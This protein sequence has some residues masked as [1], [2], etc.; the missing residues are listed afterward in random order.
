M[1][2]WDLADWRT[3]Y[4][5]TGSL[6]E[7]VIHTWTGLGLLLVMSQT[8]TVSVVSLLKHWFQVEY[9]PS[10]RKHCFFTSWFLDSSTSTTILFIICQ[11][12]SRTYMSKMP[13][14]LKTWQKMIG[15]LLKKP[16]S[17]YCFLN[18]PSHTIHKKKQSD[19]IGSSLSVAAALLSSISTIYSYIT[20]NSNSFIFN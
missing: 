13:S 18:N 5:Q 7:T 20:N 10:P 9:V 12:L 1:F 14:N 15:K 3:C 16:F 11:V 2:F 19:C 8:L 17:T 6:E 4:V